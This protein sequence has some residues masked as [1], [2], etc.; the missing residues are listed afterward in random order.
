MVSTFTFITVTCKL[1]GVPGTNLSSG[2]YSYFDQAS[3]SFVDMYC[4]Y[5]H[6]SGY[7][8][9]YFSQSA[10][11][12]LPSL[13]IHYEQKDHVIIRNLNTVNKQFEST[14][15]VLPRYQDKYNVSLFLNSHDDFGALLVNNINHYLYLGFIPLSYGDHKGAK[16]GYLSNEVEAT[17]TNCDNNQ[18]N[19]IAITPEF[20]QSQCMCC[21]DRAVARAFMEHATPIETDSYLPV[22]F[23]FPT[24][25]IMFG[26][27]GT[28]LVGYFTSE[29]QGIAFGIPFDKRG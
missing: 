22:D 25:W 26:G 9:T 13:A 15:K 10:I 24:Y 8:Y 21:C 16:K 4:D 11:D 12:I 5:D 28:A 2:I 27:C 18:N 1:L 19:Y 29:T 23:Y 3:G 14:V 6:S 20:V 7:G 17:F